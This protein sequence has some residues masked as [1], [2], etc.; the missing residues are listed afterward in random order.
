MSGLF[1]GISNQKETQP[2]NRSGLTNANS[3]VLD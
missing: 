3:V 1:G 2:D